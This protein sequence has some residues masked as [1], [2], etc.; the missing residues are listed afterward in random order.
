MSTIL[1]I[2]LGKFNSVF[3][4]FDTITK[5]ARFQTVRTQPDLFR[6]IVQRHTDVTVVFEACSPAGWLH[7][8][9]EELNLPVHV[10]NT[11]GQVSH[12]GR[13]ECVCGLDSEADRKSVV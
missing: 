11:N 12:G 5:T 6:T 2:D 1:A 9:C 7:D 10:A 8:L 13:S 3:N 4:Y